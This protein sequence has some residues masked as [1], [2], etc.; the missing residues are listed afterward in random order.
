MK[1]P[2]IRELIRDAGATFLRFPFVLAV[3]A[4]GTVTALIL[5]DYEGPPQPSILF[6]ILLASALGIPVLL[7]LALV[8]E[9]RNW[10][11]A[12]AIALQ[13][14][15]IVLLSA[16]AVTVPSDLAVAPASTLIRFIFLAAA[17]HL[18]AAVAPFASRGE[19]NGFWNYNK[20]LFVR[21][22]T[23]FLFA[24]ILWLGLTVALAALKNLFGLE[25]PSKRYFELWVVISGFLMTWFFL[26]GVPRDLNALEKVAEYPRGIK[27]FAQNVL[28][29]LVFVYL[30]ILFAYMGKIVIS[31][32]WPQG[33]VSKLILGY[34]GAGILSLLL[35]HPIAGREENAWI[36]AVSRWFYVVLIPFIVMLFL[37]L[38]RRVSEY[39][40]TPGRYLAIVLGIWLAA[41]TA[42]FI[43]SKAKSIKI[44]PATLC[45]VVFL[46]SIGGWG[47]LPVSERSQIARLR[48]Q[49][50]RWGILVNGRISPVHPRIPKEETTK[51][52]S[53]LSYLK[54][55]YGYE[56]IQG[57]FGASLRE[58]STKQDG[59][60]KDPSDVCNMMSL[61]GTGG[62]DRTVE[63]GAAVEGI[64]QTAGYD[65]MV[66][67]RAI[68]TEEK[69]ATSS[70]E[71]IAYRLGPSRRDMIIRVEREGKSAGQVD[72]DFRPL[73][74]AILRECPDSALSE[75][76][77]EKLVAESAAGGLSVKAYFRMIEVEIH[78]TDTTVSSC[79]GDIFYTMKRGK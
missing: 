6:K 2:S 48:V 54:E 33:W 24:F 38:W 22:L 40:V 61:E 19:I 20:T 65:H 50:E 66:R 68:L 18:F 53:L 36:R 60:W 72:I 3:A 17:L 73:V 45:L 43:L 14:A 4:L 7:S 29:P 47:M 56:G 5:V 16:Y 79:N 31:W 35:L 77:P 71:K 27:V 76:P 37:A 46:S 10:P 58:D 78:D 62:I 42:Y 32:N 51:I 75:L 28:L 13:C 64:D 23:A 57:W 12:R 49:A 55:V 15:G 52:R 34:T 59:A 44:I 74:R 41:V 63:F 9:K 30:I 26:A 67:A 21:L 25:I 8:A 69:E 39:G 11:G 1:M 70:V